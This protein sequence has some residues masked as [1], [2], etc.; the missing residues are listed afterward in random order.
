M[1]KRISG[2]WVR[3]YTIKPTKL[4][5][6]FV[7]LL[8]NQ[9]YV[10]LSLLISGIGIVHHVLIERLEAIFDP[11]FI[12]DSYAC[13]KGKGVHAAVKRLHLFIRNLAGKNLPLYY[14]QLDI[15]N[16]FINI[17]KNI[18]YGLL[19]QKL[20]HKDLLWLAHKIIFYNHSQ[21]YI[22]KGNPL[23][24]AKLPV[25]K[26]LLQTNGKCGLPIGNLSSQ[27][28]AN[29][30]LNELDQY[31]K[32]GLKC[33]HYLRYCDDFILLDNNLDRLAEFKTMI[34]KFLEEKLHLIL[35]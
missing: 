35:M 9:N 3:I 2:N 17:D 24:V 28:F 5:E 21:G 16:F 4:V 22:I 27:F 11:I 6:Q 34:S 29:L 25:H 30:Y 13:R 18:L 20:R 15:K 1:L 33:N 7:L 12:Y 31:V 23:L 19:R 26:S 10:R 14:L 32:H 8:K